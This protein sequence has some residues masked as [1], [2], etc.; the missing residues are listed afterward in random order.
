MFFLTIFTNLISSQGIKLVDVRQSTLQNIKV[1]GL[2]VG[3]QVSNGTEHLK[4]SSCDIQ[5]CS[6]EDCSVGILIKQ[7]DE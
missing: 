2:R 5:S 3:F 6:T 4:S 1:T 7:I